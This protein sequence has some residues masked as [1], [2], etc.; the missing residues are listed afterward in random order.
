M[1]INTKTL[2]IIGAG[3]LGIQ[4]AHYAVKDHHYTDVV[5]IDDVIDAKEVHGWPVIGKTHQ[6]LDFFEEKRFDEI[7]I[8]IG[9]KHLDIRKSFYDELHPKIP[10][11]SIIHSASFIDPSVDIEE[12][13]VIYPSCSLDINS[14]IGANTILNNGCTISHDSSVGMHCFLSPRVALAGFVKIGEGCNLGINSTIIDNIT[15]CKSSQIGGGTVVIKD[16]NEP[17]LYVGNPA[18]L[19]K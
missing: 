10:F 5:F 16:I 1:F 12:G 13:C 17:G 6:I 9:Y 11:G 19:I 8:G 18:R 2:A 7:I 14:K 4:L 15:I 3:D